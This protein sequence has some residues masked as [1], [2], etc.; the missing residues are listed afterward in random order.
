MSKTKLPVVLLVL[1]MLSTVVVA[2][3][4]RRHKVKHPAKQTTTRVATGTWGGEHVRLQVTEAGATVEYDCA[5]GTLAGPLALDAHGRFS[6]A[7]TYAREGGPVRANAAPTGQPASFK[8]RVQGR[9]MT[10]TA[11]LTDKGQDVGTFTLTQGSEG[12]LW[13]CR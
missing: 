13:K 2:R 9:T 8:G 5:H 10:L 11:T 7:G 6:V 1:C 3:P 12:R 4:H